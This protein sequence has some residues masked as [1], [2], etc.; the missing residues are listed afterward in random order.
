MFEIEL[1]ICIKMRLALNNLQRLICH[2]TQTTNPASI[3]DMTLN[4]LMVRFQPWRF[5][6]CWVPLHC[7]CSQVH[8]PRVVAPDR[9]LSVGQIEQTVCKQI[10]SNTWNHLTVYKRACAHLRMLS[11]KY[12]YKSYIFNIYIY[13]YIGTGFG[14]K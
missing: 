11:T 4:C 7:H 10:Y 14:I 6:E 2:K 9:V 12:V 5:G 13:I 8:W 1:I 3:L